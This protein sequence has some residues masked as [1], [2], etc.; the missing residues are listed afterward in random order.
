MR[1]EIDTRAFSPVTSVGTLEAG[2]PLFNDAQPL[3]HGP[4]PITVVQLAGA[5]IRLV[6]DSTDE[7]T[8][9]LDSLKN[10]S[11][12][13]VLHRSLHGAQRGSVLA[14][15][16]LLGGDLGTYGRLPGRDPG[17][18]VPCDPLPR[19]GGRRGHGSSLT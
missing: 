10:A 11:Y 7:N 5:E 3:L 16:L 1:A 4:Q 14:D 2:Q 6:R 18:D 19:G 13:Q 8:R 15:Q 17:R 12:L 9:A